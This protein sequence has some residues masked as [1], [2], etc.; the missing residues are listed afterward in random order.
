MNLK[1]NL[2]FLLLQK[3]R[4]KDKGYSEPTQLIISLVV[5]GKAYF[6][7]LIVVPECQICNYF[8]VVN[9]YLINEL[10]SFG[11]LCRFGRLSVTREQS[12]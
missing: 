2:P 8:R 5:I 3:S 11:I 1:S 7:D 10:V 6:F 9:E 12:Q 4:D